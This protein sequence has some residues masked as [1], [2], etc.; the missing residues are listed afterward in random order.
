MKKRIDNKM[1]FAKSVLAELEK[2]GFNSK[3]SEIKRVNGFE[4]VGIVMYRNPDE[5]KAA[6]IVYVVDEMLDSPPEEIAREIVDML[7][8]ILDEKTY[9][10]ECA[11]Y[12]ADADYC[13]SRIVPM[14]VNYDKNLADLTNRPHRIL[15]GD[16]AL[17]YATIV[18]DED[19]DFLGTMI[20]SNE[21]LSLWNLT[22]EDLYKAVMTVGAYTLGC[23]ILPIDEVLKEAG[24][25]FLLPVP[26]YVTTN[27]YCKNG[28]GLLACPQAMP[29]EDSYIIPSSVDEFFS[30]PVR[31]C[32]PKEELIDLVKEI[33]QEDVLEDSFLSSKLYVY[34]V[35]EGLSLA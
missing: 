12:I 4:S 1:E 26:F 23:Q 15:A 6:P 9:I 13:L 17:Q 27:S 18:G 30:I 32:D 28:A 19:G 5:E 29:E 35:G 2:F 25:I 11:K 34:K 20:V 33:N 24:H 31:V 3:I 22:E 21:I 10:E 8:N 7:E 14:V 16:I